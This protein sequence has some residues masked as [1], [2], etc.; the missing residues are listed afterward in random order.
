MPKFSS[1]WF[2]NTF[3]WVGRWKKQA[4]DHNDLH[5]LSWDGYTRL[6]FVNCGTKKRSIR[7]GE[8][9][10]TDVGLDTTWVRIKEDTRTKVCCVR[11]WFVVY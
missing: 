10:L 7:M 4:K 6:N 11:T 1:N 5:L 3:T 2:H 8:L 9:L